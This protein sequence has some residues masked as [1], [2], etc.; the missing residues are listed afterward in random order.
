MS[1]TPPPE[2]PSFVVTAKDIYDLALKTSTQLTILLAQ[3]GALDKDLREHQADSR[4][5]HSDQESRLRAL[6]RGRW[7]LPTLA[8][9]IALASA[10]IA[11]IAL[12]GK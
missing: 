10:I 4:V 2:F 5:V 3:H 11:A 8:T 12:M 7:P 1:D 6:E 9:L